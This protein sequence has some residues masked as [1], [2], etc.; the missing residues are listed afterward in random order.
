MPQL[1]RLTLAVA[2]ATASISMPLLADATLGY[3]LGR[4]GLTDM[5]ARLNVTNLLDKE[6]VAS[7]YDLNFCYFGAERSVTASFHYAF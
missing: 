7:C 4:L 6:Y 2:L 1:N 5:S 3:D